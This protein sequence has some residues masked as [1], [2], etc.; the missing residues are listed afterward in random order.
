MSTLLS[1]YSFKTDTKNALG[2]GMSMS[3]L[4]SEKDIMPL[5]V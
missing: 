1:H 3:L 4:R 2:D 5:C